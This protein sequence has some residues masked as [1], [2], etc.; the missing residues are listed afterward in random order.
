MRWF[1]AIV[2]MVASSAVHAEDS[3][4]IGVGGFFQGGWSVTSQGKVLQY[5]TMQPPDKKSACITLQP[6][7]EAWASFWK[8]I[9]RI[10][11]WRWNDH[12]FNLQ[13]TDG[14]QWEIVIARDGKMIEAKGSNAFPRDD[15]SSNESPEYS[16]PFNA[17]L[18][19][20]HTLA[21]RE[22]P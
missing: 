10:D 15:G 4:F 6:S 17:L 18:K 13:V 11:P 19:A 12:Y 1:A 8:E 9:G 3:L 14:T 2:M 16:A 7:E 22:F 21:G 5:C 20:V